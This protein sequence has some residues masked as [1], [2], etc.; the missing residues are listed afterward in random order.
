VGIDD[1]Q[2]AY[3]LLRQRRGCRVAET[4]AAYHHIPLPLPILQLAQSQARELLLHHMEEA[5]H[6]KGVPQLHLVNVHFAERGHAP[7]AQ[8]EIA[9]S[10]LLKIEFFE[11]DAHTPR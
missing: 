2:R 9:K 10:R 1:E 3:S 5:R 4:E 6:E 8:V 11:A 7:P